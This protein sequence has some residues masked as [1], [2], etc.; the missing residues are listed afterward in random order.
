MNKMCVI[1]SFIFLQLLLVP[2]FGQDPLLEILKT[3]LNQQ[4]KELQKEEY[5]PYHMNYRVID[6][7]VFY[8][9]AS[10]GTLIHSNQYRQRHIVPQIRIGNPTFDNFRNRDMGAMIGRNNI[11]P[12]QLPLDDENSREAIQQSIWYETCNRYKFAVD[13]YQQ[14]L[15]ENSVQIEQEDQAPC[16]STAP[17][18]KYYE[19][20]LPD[21]CL[22]IDLKKWEEK[23]KIISDIFNK[24]DKIISGNASFA[25]VLERRYFI[26]TEGSEVVQNLP[27][28]R[29]MVDGMTKADDGMELPLSLTYFSYIPDS[30]PDLKK[31]V[32]ETYQMIDRL[33]A[34]REAP[35]VDP[36]TGPALLSGAAT[37]VF[38]HE[39]FGHRIEGQ[40]MKSEKDGQ[41]FKK[42]VGQQVLPTDL[43]VYDDP[44]LLHYAGTDL[45]GSYK[46]DDQGVKAERVNVVVNGI[47]K[48]FLMSRTPIDNHLSSNGHGRAEGGF[49]PISRQS[50]LVIESNAP[51]TNQKMRQL[52]L[53]EI[54][55]QGKE[56]GYYF[57]E[58]TSGFTFT[59][60]ESTS[61][62]NVTPLEVYKVYADG[63]PD[64]LVRG[65]NLIGTPLSMFSNIIYAGG[66]SQVFAGM[67]GAESGQIPVT[68]IAPMIIVNKVEMQRKAKSKEMLP[69]LK[70]PELKK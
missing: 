17:V 57:T 59:G 22:P 9:S 16:F 36:F 63:R 41:T 31:I 14:A 50:N 64:Q 38:F 3:E 21:S 23:M 60:R 26:N 33:L 10:F 48:D 13:I 54:Q 51:K 15:T 7:K 67:C 40:R 25:Y 2:A 66:E 11:S 62:F 5:P 37:G 19:S 47:L 8:I 49:D 28:A 12:A 68:A 69:I 43:Q 65:V 20:P 55:K 39:I 46:Y 45:N 52:L 24:D 29:I 61:A 27:Y 58:V 30:L 56:Y 34:L 35:I 18:A 4:M 1:L 42:M 70:R 44:T 6:K 53:Q 32:A